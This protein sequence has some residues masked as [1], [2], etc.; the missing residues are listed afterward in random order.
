MFR[1]GVWCPLWGLPC[2]GQ[3]WVATHFHMARVETPSLQ[4][5]SHTRHAALTTNPHFT[6]SMFL[7]QKNGREIDIELL[8]VNI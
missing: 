2:V 8:S 1:D 6:N 4:L 5:C 3:T 7:F